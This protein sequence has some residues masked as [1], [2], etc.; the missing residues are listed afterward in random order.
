[1]PRLLP[2]THDVSKSSKL[3]DKRSRKDLELFLLA[4]VSR[5]IVTP[6]DLKMSAA[7]SPGA[8]IPALNRLETAGHLQ[9]GEGGPRNRQEYQIT[10]KGAALLQSS[11]RDLL[12]APPGSDLEVTLR[13]AS[14]ALFMG[15]PKRSVSEYLLRAA[16]AMKKTVEQ[17]TRTPESGKSPEQLFQWMRQIAIS[18]RSE[19]DA[20]ML[21]K[22]AR[23]ISRL[24]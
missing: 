2:Y 24:K 19:T 20:S 21:R 10:R 14:L 8:S 12:Q 7:I 23:T 5:G 17:K 3:P 22:I 11:W 4:L 1:M 6:Y 15:E 9:K 13:I 16:E 18:N